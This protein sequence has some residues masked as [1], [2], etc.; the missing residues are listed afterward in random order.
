LPPPLQTERVVLTLTARPSFFEEPANANRLDELR[1]ILT[2]APS[3]A[4]VAAIR[5]RHGVRRP[6]TTTCFLTRFALAVCDGR[7]S[8]WRGRHGVS[9]VRHPARHQCCYNMLARRPATQADH[10]ATRPTDCA[11]TQSQRPNAWDDCPRPS[12]TSKLHLIRGMRSAALHAPPIHDPCATKT[13]AAAHRRA[14]RAT[15]HDDATSPYPSALDLQ[16]TCINGTRQPSRPT[17]RAEPQ[18]QRPKVCSAVAA[19]AAENNKGT[20]PGRQRWHIR[21]TVRAEPQ[22]QR[23]MAERQTTVA[24]ASVVRAW[25]IGKAWRMELFCFIL[26]P[27]R[28][29]HQ[30]PRSATAT[31]TAVTP[32]HQTPDRTLLQNTIMLCFRASSQQPAA[33]NNKPTTVAALRARHANGCHAPTPSGER[34]TTVRRLP[35]T[36]RH[37]H[38]Q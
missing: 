4:S 28:L 36:R 27:L 32:Q 5:L 15:H 29:P 34:Q 23:Q 10:E 7:S 20:Q 30:L 22:S 35:P 1:F 25:R 8:Q 3:T 14:A 33:S 6:S 17:V 12:P 16:R 37:A 11:E 26:H 19:H 2:R 18:S 13:V 31:P 24:A 9:P 21:P 38:W